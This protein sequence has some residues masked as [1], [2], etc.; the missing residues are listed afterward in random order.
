MEDEASVLPTYKRHLSAV[1][2][3]NAQDSLTNSQITSI[4]D[5]FDEIDMS[6]AHGLYDAAIEK[7]LQGCSI[8]NVVFTYK[9]TY[10]EWSFDA[11]FYNPSENYDRRAAI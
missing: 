9:F 2:L 8:A 10:V 4:N 7:Y 6:I 1:A 3:T 11:A 5:A